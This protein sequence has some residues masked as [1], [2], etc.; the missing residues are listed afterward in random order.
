MHQE[1]I[2]QIEDP[3]YGKLSLSTL[4][5]IASA[6][7]VGLVVRFV[8][9]SE[10]A[11]WELSLS[12]ESLKVSSFN[13]DK[14]FQKTESP[15]AENS[16]SDQVTYLHKVDQA[17]INVIWAES[18]FTTKKAAELKLDNDSVAV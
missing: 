13:E 17:A 11:E 7:D 6:F 16:I 10:L 8:P 9:F 3:N 1:R 18:L 12:S 4:K 14:Y 5:R 15:E 2:S